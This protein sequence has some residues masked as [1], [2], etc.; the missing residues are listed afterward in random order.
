MTQ[1]FLNVLYLLALPK[2]QCLSAFATKVELLGVPHYL[3]LVSLADIDPVY[4]F[5][6]VYYFPPVL[7]NSFFIPG[8]ANWFVEEYKR[9]RNKS[10]D[11]L[12]DFGPI[13]N[14]LKIR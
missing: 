8:P 4:Y 14:T 3:F 9:E 6:S 10:T 5:T 13:L 12:K 11:S 1:D 2:H 7:L